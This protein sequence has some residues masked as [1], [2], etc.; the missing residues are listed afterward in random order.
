MLL[1]A[2]MLMSGKNVNKITY[3]KE[4]VSEYIVMSK[5]ENSVA[6]V[7]ADKDIVTD[8]EQGDNFAI[9]KMTKDQA[10][11]IHNKNSKII[12]EKDGEVAALSEK[13]S[14][15]IAQ[16][17]EWNVKAINAVY[18]DNK[19]AQNIIKVAVIDSGVDDYN[20]IDLA[21]NINLV[22]GEED[23]SPLYQDV[24]GHGSSVAGIIAAKNDGRGISGIA[25]EALIY[26]AKVLDGENR[27][28]ISRVIDG[29]YWAIDNKVN[30]INMSFGTSKKSEA[31]HQAVKEAKKA[32]ILMIAAA[33]N[34]RQIEYPA[35]YDE[36]MAVGSVDTKGEISEKSA[37]GEEMEIVAPGEQ[38][39][40]TG[41]FGGTVVAS[42][43]SMSAP[44]IT[45]VAVK[46]W[47]KDN[48]V[49]ADFIRQLLDASANKFTSSRSC[50][51]GLVD[52]SYA[53]KIYDDFKKTY[54]EG[55]E[56]EENERFVKDNTKP[57]EDFSEVN[58]VEGRWD[59]DD[60]VKAVSNSKLTKTQISIV[61][62][63][64]VYSD[65]NASTK[66]LGKRPFWHG[67]YKCSNYIS[68]YVYATNIAVAFKN[69][70]SASSA[71]IP[72]GLSGADKQNMLNAIN[73][74]S[75]S[76]L[77][78]TPSNKNK[79]LFVWGMAIHNAMDVYAHS[80]WGNFSG[81]WR[82]LDHAT[83]DNPVNGYADRTDGKAF[84][85]R[86]TTACDVAKK[87]LST[88]VT[89]TTGKVSDFLPSNSY[90][91]GGVTWKIKNLASFASVLDNST[92]ASLQKYSY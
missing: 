30:I 46:L 77:L 27:S 25:P 54:V 2:G 59:K 58:Y 47:E 10:E 73:S 26:S 9:V 79:S 42:G 17:K 68:S 71:A 56:L 63:G 4:S 86:Y 1:A 23:V 34:N 48:T 76:Q 39:C 78:A 62:S 81:T 22:E 84:P 66:G 13:D 35:A 85:G 45:G 24:S 72:A 43:T 49:S 50:G 75:W 65:I 60:H 57:I 89:G 88:Y 15:S 67:G 5:N 29:I 90:S 8:M 36:V 6:D 14:K 87:S 12:V 64:V 80:A 40:S 32:G 91:Y 16:E 3:A 70:K 21:G 52:Y 33:G 7:V 28:T 69:G 83:N 53:E 37:I 55:K 61:K 74:F 18:A 51:N 31:L 20:D 44:H 41:A 92:A 19:Q 38:I 11:E 82:H